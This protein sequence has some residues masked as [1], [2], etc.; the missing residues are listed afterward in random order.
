MH[1]AIITLYPGN[2]S[3]DLINKTAGGG[4]HYSYAELLSDCESIL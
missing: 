4:H 1:T 2:K 3:S